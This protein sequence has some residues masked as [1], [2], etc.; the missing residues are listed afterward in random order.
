[1][2]I[3][4]MIDQESVHDVNVQNVFWPNGW[5]KMCKWGQDKHVH[6]MMDM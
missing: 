4:S 2:Y 3:D 1:M 6:F 5:P